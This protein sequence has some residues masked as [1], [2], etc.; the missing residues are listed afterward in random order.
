MYVIL[1]MY[2]HL[3]GLCRDKLGTITQYGLGEG[4]SAVCVC[5]L[6]VQGRPVYNVSLYVIG[7][8]LVLP[9]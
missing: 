2:I 1:A 4:F 8:E 9:C 7:S 6:R 3:E 5:A